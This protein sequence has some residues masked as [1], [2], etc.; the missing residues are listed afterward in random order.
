[1]LGPCLTFLCAPYVNLGLSHLLNWQEVKFLWWSVLHL[2]QAIQSFKS[3]RHWSLTWSLPS[4]WHLGLT[5]RGLLPAN[6]ASMSFVGKGLLGGL[7][8]FGSGLSTLVRAIWSLL[9][10]DLS[11]RSRTAPCAGWG[12]SLLPLASLNSPPQAAHVSL[13]YIASVLGPTPNSKG[14]I[15]LKCISFLLCKFPQVRKRSKMDDY[16]LKIRVQGRM[17]YNLKWFYCKWNYKMVIPLKRDSSPQSLSRL[18]DYNICFVL[19]EKKGDTWLCDHVSNF[20][21]LEVTKCH[22][23]IGRHKGVF[24]CSIFPYFSLICNCYFP[25]ISR[26][27]CVNCRFYLT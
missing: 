15:D 18:Q 1:M 9:Q 6:A 26:L 21:T 22:R 10:S 5:L 11:R 14:S 7:E 16:L 4:H 25:M 24:L 27:M 3:L 19:A 13:H 20:C 2:P 8:V 12:F 17:N 23:C